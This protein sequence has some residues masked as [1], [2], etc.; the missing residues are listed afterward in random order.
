M[1]SVTGVLLTYERQILAWTEKSH[2]LPA[3]QITQKKSL[4]QLHFITRTEHS[5]ISP[6]A[7]IV[8]NDPGAPVTFSAGRRVDSA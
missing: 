5:D 2:Y 4:E 1:M 6:T 8:L 7:I 3:D